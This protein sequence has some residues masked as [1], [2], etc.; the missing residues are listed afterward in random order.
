M[1]REEISS[2]LKKM[3]DL[4]EIKGENP[5]RIRAYRNGA[6]VLLN[7]DEPLD[8][9]IKEHRLTDFEGIGEHLAEKI[10]ELYETG[11][12]AEWD[13]LRK[14]IPETLLDLLNIQGLGPKR[15][16][17]LYK[18]LRIRT[19]SD[20]KNA[21]KNGKIAKLKGL[22]EKIEQQI[23]TSLKQFQATSG[24]RLWWDAKQIAEPIRDGLSQIKNVGSVEIAGSF[25]R[26]LETLGDLDFVVAS[27]SP[28]SVI[29]WFTTQPFCKKILAK[30]KT[31]AS[32][33]LTEGLQADLRVVNQ[34]EFP[35]ALHY[36]TGSK[37]HVIGM[38]KRAQKKGYSL[39]EY[40]IKF[41][42]KKFTSKVQN[43]KDLFELF[44]LSY[45]PPELRENQGEFEAAAKKKIPTLIE[46]SDLK[47]ALH[48]H[49]AAS[50]GKNSLNEMVE[51]AETLQWQYIGITDH[52]KSSVQANGLNE[53]RIEKQLDEIRKINASGKRS[54][55]VFAG[56]E[57][58]ILANG[59]LDFPTSF[60]KQLDYVVVS[61]HSSFQMDEQKMTKRLIKAIENPASTIIGHLT[62]RLLLKRKS[63]ALNIPKV[64]DAC[65]A[66]K[67]IVE[68]NG[69]PQ[70]L[71][72]DWRHW[73]AASEKGLLCCIN[74]DAH[75]IHQLSFVETGI[76]IARKGW[77]EAKN[78]INTLSLPKMKQL[79]Q[80]LH[81]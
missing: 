51:A 7:I 19:L 22:S 28:I 47:G 43:E 60:L 53:R 71:D 23:L 33:Q 45:I 62:G 58:D 21:V 38:R 81:P 46:L 27:S 66:N 34:E 37:E 12:L 52:S 63:Y 59:A 67:K 1:K 55:H 40:G 65:I 73:K 76:Q 9:L 39:S 56:L 24:R 78:V 57:C 54:I 68:L 70:R 32:I 15:V 3:A 26:K 17:L 16:H 61:I 18:K 49:T 13:T 50:D 8:L 2:I 31:K 80:K 14:V 69:N 44:D 36:F 30:G 75:S 35:F 10:T 77:L 74:P 25:R 42:R 29:H 48:N 20:L 41:Q 79:L 64:L 72:M 11:G 6:R 5:F 4:L